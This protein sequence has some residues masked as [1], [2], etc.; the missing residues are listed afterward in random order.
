MLR[1]IP[2]GLAVA[3]LT[4]AALVL[5]TAGAAT[6]APSSTPTPVCSS[7]GCDRSHHVKGH[8]KAHGRTGHGGHNAHRRDGYDDF[9][10]DG[11][12]RD[13]YGY[14]RDGYRDGYGYGRDGYN[15]DGYRDGYG[16]G[17]DG[18]GPGRGLFGLGLLGLL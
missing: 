3:G 8:E 14:G 4:A 16:Y 5:P 9:G 6:A 15:R 11:G 18:Y 7:H 1:S 10:R 13:G 2:R 17:R 12:R